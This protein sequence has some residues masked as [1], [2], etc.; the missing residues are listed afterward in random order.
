MPKKVE[1]DQTTQTSNKI[2]SWIFKLVHKKK[3]NTVKIDFTPAKA[4]DE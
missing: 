4:I 2:N 1:L 3:M